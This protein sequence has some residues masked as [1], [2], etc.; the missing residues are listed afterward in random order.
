M[1]KIE[2][3]NTQSM[4]VLMLE[5]AFKAGQESMEAYTVWYDVYEDEQLTREKYGF[6]HW[7]SKIWKYGRTK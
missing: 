5:K 4:L 3:P 7:L 6:R 2:L 1:S